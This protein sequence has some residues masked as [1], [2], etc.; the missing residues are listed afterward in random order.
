MDYHK[1]I[2][3]KKFYANCT[4]FLLAEQIR[5]T[6][7]KKT[8]KIYINKKLLIIANYFMNYYKKKD[9]KNKYLFFF[10]DLKQIKNLLFE[11]NLNNSNK[12]IEKI[13]C[14]NFYLNFF[15]MYS[16]IIFIF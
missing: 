4:L 2:I 15:E 10:V 1:F 12:Y 13:K 8:D 14:Y 9:L 6:N 3:S 5:Y 11:C 16:S 7:P